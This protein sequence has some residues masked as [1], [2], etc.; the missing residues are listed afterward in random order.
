MEQIKCVHH[1]EYDGICKPTPGCL[2]CRMSYLN[3]HPYDP[4]DG[5]DMVEIVNMIMGTLREPI[6]GLVRNGEALSAKVNAL[7]E[8]SR[9]LATEVRDMASKKQADPTKP[10]STKT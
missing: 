10:D 3:K 8:A 2:G 1:K 5:R 7:E 4:V 9:V 6:T